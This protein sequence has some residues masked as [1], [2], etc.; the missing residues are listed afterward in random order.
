MTK[1]FLYEK[2]EAA[3][4]QEFQQGI[5]HS[6]SGMSHPNPS[7]SMNLEFIGLHTEIDQAGV[8]GKGA[9]VWTQTAAQTKVRQLAI[10]T[11][12]SPETP[13]PTAA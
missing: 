7:F 3:P 11:V 12:S 8:L 10:R 2:T 13:T 1:P 5:L 9:S 6:M 4:A